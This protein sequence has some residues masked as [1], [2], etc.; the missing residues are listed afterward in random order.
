MP[1]STQ[2]PATLTQ[3]PADWASVLGDE[4]DKPYFKQLAEFIC[5][6][7]AQHTIFPPEDEV[8][9]ALNLT[10]FEKVRVLLLGQDP[11][12][13]PGH[14]HGL[15]F[16]VKVG[17]KHPASLRN[18]FKEL[19]ED[20]G[21]TIPNHGN[22]EAWAKQGVLMLNAV[23]TVRDGEANSHAGK[24]WEEFTDAII[25]ALNTRQKPIVFVLWGNYAQKKAKHIDETRHTVIRSAHPSPLSVKKFSGSRP[26]SK[27][28][29]ALQEYSTAPIDWQLAKL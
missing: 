24:G 23:L 26:F 27:I 21:C 29:S 8:Y 19:Q 10:P 5:N 15:C 17:V 14:A 12:P 2:T 9:T 1:P 25:R 11:Y 7:R 20:L 3:L 16:S 18:I 13:T 22:L 6:E 28:N 4:F